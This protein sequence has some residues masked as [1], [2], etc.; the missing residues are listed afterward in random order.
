MPSIGPATLGIL[1]SA[2]LA[3]ANHAAD[4]VLRGASAFP[5]YADHQHEYDEPLREGL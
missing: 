3:Q 4:A 1:P 2:V 5:L